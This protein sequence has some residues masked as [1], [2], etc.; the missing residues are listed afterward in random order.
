MF[1]RIIEQVGVIRHVAH[2]LVSSLCV[3]S[4]GLAIAAEALDVQRVLQ[5]VIANADLEEPLP[6]PTRHRLRFNGPRLRLPSSLAVSPERAISATSARS[7][8][9]CSGLSGSSHSNF[10]GRDR[11]NGGNVKPGARRDAKVSTAC[12]WSAPFSVA[13]WYDA[14][15]GWVLPFERKTVRANSPSSAGVHPALM[16]PPR[17]SRC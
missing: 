3:F 7:S 4:V 2:F 10:F 5:R 8:C 13:Y 15:V 6:E 1:D 16:R 12:G 17:A 9:G 14:A 11:L